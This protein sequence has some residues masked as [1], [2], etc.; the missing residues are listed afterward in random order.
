MRAVTGQPTGIANPQDSSTSDCGHRHPLQHAILSEN[1]ANPP[2][3]RL[4]LWQQEELLR[5]REIVVR[6]MCGLSHPMNRSGKRTRSAWAFSEYAKLGAR[7]GAPFPGRTSAYCS[8][9]PASAND[10]QM[11]G[12][13]QA[14]LLLP[15]MSRKIERRSSLARLYCLCES[16]QRPNYSRDSLVKFSESA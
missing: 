13:S 14:L 12:W 11:L 9:L 3:R 15:G 6:A 1:R 5:V 16:M 4:L 8:P 7:I 10:A 2:A